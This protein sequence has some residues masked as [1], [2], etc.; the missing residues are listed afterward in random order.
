MI[1]RGKWDCAIDAVHFYLLLFLRPMAIW[2]IIL[3]PLLPPPRDLSIT[4]FP[5]PT[6]KPKNQ[7]LYGSMGPK[8]LSGV[9][10]GILLSFFFFLS[11]PSPKPLHCFPGT[12]DSIFFTW[13]ERA[14][15]A[16]SAEKENRVGGRSVAV[17]FASGRKRVFGLW[18][19]RDECVN[20]Y[21]LTVPTN[22]AT[23]HPNPL[24]CCVR[25]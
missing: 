24:L 10:G 18:L 11:H 2:E 13:H 5:P 4:S 19:W 16:T 8:Q 3:L 12:E 23:P 14:G 25:N 20:R 7:S 21:Y 22:A 9:I 15:L 17:A 6:S 1:P